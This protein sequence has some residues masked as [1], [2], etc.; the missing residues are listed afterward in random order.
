MGK[1]FPQKGYGK[2]VKDSAYVPTI[3][4]RDRF[5]EKISITDGCHLWMGATTDQGYGSFWMNGRS[6]QAHKVVYLLAGHEFM[7]GEEIDH[8]CRTR[9]CV[10]LDHLRIVDHKTNC[11]ENSIG[12]SAVNA[13]KTHCAKG[14]EYSVDNTYLFKEKDHIRRRCKTCFLDRGKRTYL[15]NKN[16][17]I[18][19]PPTDSTKEVR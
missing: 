6:I 5:L 12:F 13:K 10:N 3:K 16:K 9:N 1:L 4:D 2:T 14:H 8:K 19:A 15:A 11:L 18:L 7:D 17:R